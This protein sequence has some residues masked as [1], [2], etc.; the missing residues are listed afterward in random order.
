MLLFAATFTW[1]LSLPLRNVSIVAP[2]RSLMLFAAGV[3]YALS[4]DP[5]APRLAFVLWLV[6]IWAARMS[7]YLTAR[8]MR[9][10]ED[11]GYQAIRWKSLH[12]VFW[13]LLAGAAG[14]VLAI[15]LLLANARPASASGLDLPNALFVRR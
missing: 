14:L 11:P 15:L 12:R 9:A 4:A 7:I 5:R 10:P 2:L 13:L 3:L 1:L 8:T 6:A